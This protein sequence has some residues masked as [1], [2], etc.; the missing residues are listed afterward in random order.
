MVKVCPPMPYRLA[1]TL[2]HKC[3]GRRR[4]RASDL[5]AG[6]AAGTHNPN[7][8]H[9]GSRELSQDLRIL[10]VRSGSQDAV[11]IKTYHLLSKTESVPP[12]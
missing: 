4:A 6:A 10:R 5:R 3:N 2:S 9:C 12:L 8:A 11:E 1:P 7:G